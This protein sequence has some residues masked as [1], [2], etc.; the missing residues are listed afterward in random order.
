LTAYV[1]AKHANS[2]VGLKLLWGLEIAPIRELW[3]EVTHKQWTGLLLAIE[4]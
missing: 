1:Q 2:V 3:Y 4:D